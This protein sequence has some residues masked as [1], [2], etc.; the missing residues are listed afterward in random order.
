METEVSDIIFFFG[1]FH[2]IV[3]HLPIGVLS[4]AFLLEVLCR[5]KN[6]TQYRPAVSL[7][8]WIGSAFAVITAAFG[9]MLG[10]EGGF[11]N[12]LLSIHQ[13]TGI[14][15]AVLSIITLIFYDQ[16]RKHKS[17]AFHNA[18]LSSITGTVIL[19]AV[20]GHYGGALTHGSDYLTE[21]MPDALRTMTGL[22]PNEKKEFRKIV[23]LSEAVVYHDIVYPILDKGCVSCHNE[24]KSKGDLKLHTAEG[25]LKGGE[26]GP[27]FV[28]GSPEESSIMK[29]LYLPESHDDHMPPKGKLQLSSDEI[30][31]LSWWIREGAP[32]DKK[33]SE[34]KVDQPLQLVLNT[35]VD[36][37]ANKSA[38]EK[39]LDGDVNPA[40]SQVVH[41]L[42]AK[43]LRIAPL[44]SEVH[45]LK[46]S[47]SQNL[48]ADSLGNDL[49]ALAEQLTWLDLG[50]SATT[51]KALANFGSFKN[52]TR[53]HLEQTKITDEGLSYL[54][55]LSYLEYLNLY[56]TAVS[57]KGIIGLAGLK[58][59]KRLYV[60]Q[61]NVTPEGASRLQQE[62]PGLEVNLGIPAM[63]SKHQRTR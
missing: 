34:L 50:G 44:R 33:V 24:R 22:P 55:E 16:S 14:G 47:A 46:A 30:K 57:D 37:D 62:L 32:F 59:L 53:L 17:V 58:N 48:S 1:R 4:L 43:G 21:F 2:P 31:L 26:N 40:D 45:W 61:T 27:A 9:Y 20:A 11:D 36:A 5:F 42:Q 28:A 10:M 13:W 12:E 25:L 38:V 39:L 19:M 8:L 41:N 29:R 60:W 23:N 51:D 63:M 15:V 6:F 3:L 52:L 35:L 54:K 7:T 49:V 56:G 18:Y